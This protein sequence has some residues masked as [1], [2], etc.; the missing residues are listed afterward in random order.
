MSKISSISNTSNMM[1][2]YIIRNKEATVEY[3]VTHYRAFQGRIHILGYRYTIYLGML[4][5]DAILSTVEQRLR[6][7]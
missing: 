6:R 1:C 3:I 7:D 2:H 5:L 4:L